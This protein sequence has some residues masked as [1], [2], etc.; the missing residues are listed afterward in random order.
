ME[1]RFK[2]TTKSASEDIPHAA[3]EGRVHD[4]TDFVT[5]EVICLKDIPV[6]ERHRQASQ[7]LYLKRYE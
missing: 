5:V 1:Y 7:P 4:K 6:A 3:L 2:K